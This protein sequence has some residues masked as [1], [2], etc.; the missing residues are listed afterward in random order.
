LSVIAVVSGG[1]LATAFIA[2]YGFDLWPCL[3]CYEQRI[4]YLIAFVVAAWA[5]IPGVDPVARRHAVFLC[6]LL[7]AGNTALA[8]FH[9][10]VE[11]KWWPGLDA[12]G[13]ALRDLNVS[14]L[15]AALSK[16]APPGCDEAAIRVFGISMAGGN[17]IVC[18]VMTLFCLWAALQKPRWATP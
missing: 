3:L 1:A 15:A 13:G 5:T 4:P 14:D 10:G 8:A 9:A 7:F 2:Q 6:V 17:V 16:P 12:C 11:Y 18:G